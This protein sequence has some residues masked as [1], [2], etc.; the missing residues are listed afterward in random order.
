MYI[1]QCVTV[2]V[3]DLYYYISSQVV[4]AD[5]NEDPFVRDFG[6]S[7]DQKMVTVSGRI[8]P[9]PLLQYGGKVRG[10]GERG[11]AKERERGGEGKGER[12]RGGGERRERG[13]GGG[14]GER[15]EREGGRGKERE[16][17]REGGG[18]KERE[19]ERGGEREGRGGGGGRKRIKGWERDDVVFV[20]DVHAHV[21]R[22]M[23]LLF[24]RKNSCLQ[25]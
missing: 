5:F 23:Q 13:G 6:I 14:G 19:R 10:G 4:R 15:R 24:F 3:D 18:G 21:S 11:G 7:I 16:R 25:V 1:V 22:L 8:L 9:P 20:Q 2:C 17:E 12:E